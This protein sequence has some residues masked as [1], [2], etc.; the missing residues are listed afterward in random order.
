MDKWRTPDGQ[1]TAQL[2]HRRQEWLMEEKV[3]LGVTTEPPPTHINTY[4]QSLEGTEWKD[5]PR[6][7]RVG[8]A[9]VG[10]ALGNL[11]HYLQVLLHTHPS[12]NSAEHQ[13]TCTPLSKQWES[14][15][16]WWHTPLVTALGRQRQANLCE[17]VASLV[18]RVN[19]RTDG[20]RYTEKPCLKK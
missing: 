4:T 19:S 6:N 3:G 17:F 1:F 15:G 13:A 20:Q 2:E 8:T 9:K 14:A 10:D 5:C 11:G 18:Y 16:Q 12:S 7:R